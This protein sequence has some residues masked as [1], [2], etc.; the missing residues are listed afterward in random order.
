MGF[1]ITM[2]TSPR[3]ISQMFVCD[4]FASA[5]YNNGTIGDLG[6]AFTGG[7]VTGQA[8]EANHPGIVR[9]DTSAVSGTTASLSARWAA[10][11]GTFLPAEFFDLTWIVRL[12]TNDANTT[13]RIGVGNDITSTGIVNGMY[14]EKLDADTN[15]FFVSRASSTQTRTDSGVAVGT[16]WVRLR[17][18]RTGASAIGYSLNGGAE[19][20]ISTN[21]PTASLMP[22]LHI[23]NSA[24]ASKTIDVDYFDLLITGMTR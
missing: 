2:P 13:V 16:D 24:V 6:W 15:W 8:A 20:T 3:D 9:R 19:T 22:G 23:V 10:S 17:I 4:D 11:A 14:L 7:T 1:R 5:T 18:R 21:I 12:N